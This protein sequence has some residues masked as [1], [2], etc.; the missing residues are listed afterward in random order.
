[1]DT[2][3]FKMVLLFVLLP[4]V[5]PLM[6]LDKFNV[7][8]DSSLFLFVLRL[9]YFRLALAGL[10]LFGFPVALACGAAGSPGCFC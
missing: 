2:F 6:A 5:S 3:C 1:M 8:A 7:I 9:T 4:G 10:E